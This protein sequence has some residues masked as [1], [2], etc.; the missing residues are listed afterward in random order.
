[1][2]IENYTAQSL[3]ADQYQTANLKRTQAL[4][5]TFSL[6]EAKR[7]QLSNILS[8]YD[9]TNC[10]P[11]QMADLSLELYEAG[12]LNFR[13]HALLSFQPE[14]GPQYDELCRSAGVS[15]TRN[16][17][18]NYIQVWEQRLADKKKENASPQM[19]KNTQEI[20]DILHELVRLSKQSRLNPASREA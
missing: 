11:R 4:S 18:K 12:A 2:K 15:N 6:D 8:R 3:A 17:P 19:I 7:T 20:V 10:T 13:Q 14:L 5:S 16:V 1:M 9:I